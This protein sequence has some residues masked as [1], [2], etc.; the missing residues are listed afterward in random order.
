[1]VH[2][3][4]RSLG[5]TAGALLIERIEGHEGPGRHVVIPGELGATLTAAPG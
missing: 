3:P 4:T 5:T 1:V 2:L